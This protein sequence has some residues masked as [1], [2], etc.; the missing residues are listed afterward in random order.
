VALV[1]SGL[2]VVEVQPEVRSVLYRYVM[3]AVEMA[4]TE[5]IAVAKLSEDDV[6]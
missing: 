4:L 6:R 3:F 1:T 5:A 2:V